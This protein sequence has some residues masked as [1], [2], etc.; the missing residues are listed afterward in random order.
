MTEHRDGNSLAGALADIF[1]AEIT[2]A[3]VQ[4]RACGLATTL[5]QLLVYGPEPG[6]VGRCPGCAEHVLRVAKTPAGTW[7]DLGGSTS[8]LFSTMAPSPTGAASS[9]RT[10]RVSS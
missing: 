6:Y 2:S 4:C 5:A 8:L 9:A 7:L 10:G 1:A 3:Q